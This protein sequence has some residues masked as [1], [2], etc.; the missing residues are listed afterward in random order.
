MTENCFNAGSQPPSY[1]IYAG[2]QSPYTSHGPSYPGNAYAVPQGPPY[3][4]NA[5]AVPQGPSAPYLGNT[6][7]APQGPSAPYPSNTFAAPQ[8]PSAPYP[9]NTFTASQGPS[10]P[11]P[12]NAFAAPQAPS[13]PYLGNTF[14]APQGPSAPYGN[15]FVAL[16]AP[17]SGI[18]FTPSQ[19]P[20][21]LL[22]GNA[23]TA[24]QRS[25]LPYD[26]SFMAPQG[27]SVLPPINTFAANPSV[28]PSGNT[29]VAP[30]GSSA[31]HS[32]NTFAAPQ[33]PLY[34]GNAYM[35]SY[36]VNPASPI[37]EYNGPSGYAEDMVHT[38]NTDLTDVSW[39]GCPPVMADLI[40]PSSCPQVPAGNVP[41][42]PLPMDFAIG[43]APV[44]QQPHQHVTTTHLWSPCLLRCI[45][46][47]VVRFFFPMI[48][49]IEQI[50]I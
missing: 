48:V 8:G 46:A 23:I 45:F 33:V 20:S 40:I 42:L 32:G 31:S 38:F 30:Q 6:F 29:F 5:F 12:G 44:G 49:A 28:F 36:H 50:H 35:S 17:Y 24:P 37:V 9:S 41:A 18:T 3:S 43:A 11:Y 19:G 1:S 14:T 39:D 16:Q 27:P 21:V 13:A 22:Y 26:N 15:T 25:A 10:V 47:S 7:A 4:G 34:S 2:P